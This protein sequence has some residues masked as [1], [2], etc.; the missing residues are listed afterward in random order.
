MSRVRP[1]EVKALTPLLEEDWDSPEELAEALI[2]K[3]D[4]VRTSRTSYVWV[5]QFGPPKMG[6][7]TWYSGA[8]PYPGQ[9][10]AER[11]AKGFPGAELASAVAVVPILTPEGLEAKI[12]ETG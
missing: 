7:L 11:A 8:G 1:L 4:E 9:K 6:G 5:A 10:S 3:L 2:R 12:R